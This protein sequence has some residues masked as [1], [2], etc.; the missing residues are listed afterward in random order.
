MST[1]R[2]KNHF[3]GRGIGVVLQGPLTSVGRTYFSS[4]LH[5]H[6]ERVLGVQTETDH[7]LPYDARANVMELAR[8]FRFL[9]L[10]VV[11]SGWE[12]DRAWLEQ[13]SHRFDALV[14]SNDDL[15][16]ARSH[17]HPALASRRLLL[18]NK[19]KLYCSSWA[20]LQAAHETLGLR[21]ALKMR[22]D[23][24]LDPAHLVENLDRMHSQ[25]RYLGVQRLVVR[26]G[27]PDPFSLADFFTQGSTELQIALFG[28]L[29]HRSVAGQA[30]H[31]SP[32]PD[33]FLGLLTQ[34]RE[35]RMDGI[36]TAQAALL[37]QLIWRG[38]PASVGA[39]FDSMPDESCCSQIYKM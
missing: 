33:F 1:F 35:G 38:V 39:L 17:S 3:Q 31:E 5:A 21:Y 36:F 4:E 25:P 28:D 19:E 30:Y 11:Y 14:I 32:H 2:L 27:Q 37:R 24:F 23:I 8:I 7:A 34:V 20:G 18:N 16:Q 6:D 15:A 13:E 10:P 22:S 12:T 26:D 29:Y 9:G